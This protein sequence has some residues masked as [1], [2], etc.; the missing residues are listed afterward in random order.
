MTAPME[1]APA[2][3]SRRYIL[4]A[5]VVAVFAIIVVAF[6]K[7]LYLDPRKIPTPMLDQAAPSFDLPPLK[8]G[9]PGLKTADLKGQVQLVNVFASWCVPCRVEHPLLMRL[10]KEGKV[11]VNGIA[12][13]DTRPNASAFLDEL[14][15]PYKKIGFD[16]SGRAGIDWGVYGVPETYVIDRDGRIRY[17]VVGPI[18]PQE[19]T[20]RL[21]PLIEKLQK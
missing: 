4:P 20:E 19:L 12:W 6:Y 17:K 1:A 8:D 16:G 15:N 21:L 13:K 9:E 5:L 18:M 11:Q 2:R 10:A 7:A 3:P 14:G